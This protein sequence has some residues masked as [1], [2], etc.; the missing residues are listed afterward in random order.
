MP[1]QTHGTQK[2]EHALV[3]V[4]IENRE[5][6]SRRQR[7]LTCC[8]PLFAE[9]HC[10]SLRSL[11]LI[12]AIALDVGGGNLLPVPQQRRGG[13]DGE[14]AKSAESAA[15]V[16]GGVCSAVDG[17]AAGVQVSCC[18][19]LR[20]SLFVRLPQQNAFALAASDGSGDC[21]RSCILQIYK[22]VER[23]DDAQDENQQN[24]RAQI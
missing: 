18:R 7:K 6:Q 14:A 9:T 13:V 23:S 1:Q 5:S 4:C 24:A 17:S 11:L 20:L 21:Q 19:F 22:I 16:A 10:G 2:L 3:P 12:A 15:A 8:V